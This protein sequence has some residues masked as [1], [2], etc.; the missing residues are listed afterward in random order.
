MVQHTI[1]AVL[2]TLCHRQAITKNPTHTIFFH[3]F[4]FIYSR[5]R[6]CAC[7]TEARLK[8]QLKPEWINLMV[9][10]KVNIN[11]YIWDGWVVNERVMMRLIISGN[12]RDLASLKYIFH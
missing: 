9:L 3:L 11:N 7:M 8:P 1:T 2:L 10:L 12:N 5:P 6:V 4:H